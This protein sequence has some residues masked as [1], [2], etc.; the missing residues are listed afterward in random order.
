[1]NAQTEFMHKNEMKTKGIFTLRRWMKYWY[2]HMTYNM[3]QYMLYNHPMDFRESTA[4]PMMLES[5]LRIDGFYY[6][7]YVH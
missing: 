4:Q 5:E 3:P 6:T 7:E 1:M 2:N